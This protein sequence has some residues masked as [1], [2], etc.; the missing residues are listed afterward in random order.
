MIGMTLCSGIGAP[1]L[2]APWVDWRCAAEIEDFPRAVL[3]ERF[4]YRMPDDHNQGDPLLWGDMTEV[5][6]EL[7]R[8]RGVPLPDILVAGTP[9]QA[10]S[11]G[12]LRLGVKDPR[13]NLTLKFVETCHA[14]VDARLDGRLVVLWENVAGVLSDENNA[15]GCLLAGL[16]GADDPLCTPDGGNWPCAGMVAGPRARTAWRIFDA[17][18]FHTDQRRK[19]VLLLVD[20]GSVV[21]PA[22]I[23]FERKGAGRPPRSQRPSVSESQRFFSSGNRARDRL[24]T[25]TLSARDHK[26]PQIVASPDYVR[27]LM[28]L[29]YGRL[30]GF[31]DGHC[32]IIYKGRPAPDRV[33]YKA[34]GNSMAVTKIKWVMDRIRMELDL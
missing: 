29:E 33:K 19:R 22:K 34:F 25:D 12:G 17:Q 24:L 23:L 11:L 20:Y 4:G 5:T 6:P 2:A 10:F 9:C 26:D 3:A 13:G 7:L 30:Q 31:P 21:D 14:I 16:V 8:R 1:E 15:F 28:P 32:D 27:R 18:Y